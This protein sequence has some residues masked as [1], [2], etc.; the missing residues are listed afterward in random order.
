MI[1]EKRE[2]QLIIKKDG[3][4]WTFSGLAESGEIGASMGDEYSHLSDEEA[5]KVV[6]SE[7]KNLGI[8]GVKEG[9][10]Q[11]SKI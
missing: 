2:R 8:N 11:D 3:R 10:D 5:A 6:L 1:I 7:A 4:I 9:A